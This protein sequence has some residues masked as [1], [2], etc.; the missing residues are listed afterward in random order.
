MESQLSLYDDIRE[1][2]I[3]QHRSEE[4]L[5]LI[6]KAFLFAQRLHQNQYRVSEEPYIIHPVEVVKIFQRQ[7]F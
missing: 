3:E 2:L 6:E 4:D 1:K 7:I 5:A